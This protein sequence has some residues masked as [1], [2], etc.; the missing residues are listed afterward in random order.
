MSQRSVERSWNLQP[1]HGSVAGQRRGGD[2]RSVLE[3]HDEQLRR[4][5]QKE[6]GLTLAQR[7]ERI[8]QQRR[9][10]L[11][12]TALW[13]RLERLGLSYQKNAA[14]RRAGP[15]CAAS[16]PGALAPGAAAVARRPAR[17]PR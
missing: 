9:K 17:L 12:T 13:H 7:C 1:Q 11:G 16:R 6:P 14:C 8:R 5:I 4:W 10:Q 3:G 15:A 2:R